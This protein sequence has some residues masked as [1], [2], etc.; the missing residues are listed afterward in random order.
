[1]HN[2][3]GVVLRACY[4]LIRKQPLLCV[5]GEPLTFPIRAAILSSVPD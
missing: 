5:L 2:D 1:V 4:S 3:T